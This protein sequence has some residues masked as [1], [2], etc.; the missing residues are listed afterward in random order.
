MARP[1]LRSARFPRKAANDSAGAGRLVLNPVTSRGRIWACRR[2]GSPSPAG[3]AD[4][5][6]LGP[7]GL[8]GLGHLVQPG[9]A[10]AG[11]SGPTGGARQALSLLCGRPPRRGRPMA[12]MTPRCRVSPWHHTLVPGPAS[13]IGVCHEQ[14]NLSRYRGC[15]AA[16]GR[17]RADRRAAQA[18]APRPARRT[19]AARG[20]A[21][22][23]GASP[24]GG[25]PHRVSRRAGSPGGTSRRR[26][27]RNQ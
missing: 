2:G 11:R 4:L 16:G 10:G 21:S 26:G 1:G 7:L 20:R 24:C 9:R 5:G 15:R 12:G 19:G 3:L 23:C 8:T 18:A 17:V 22:P 6:G 27:S 14:R 25:W 13:R